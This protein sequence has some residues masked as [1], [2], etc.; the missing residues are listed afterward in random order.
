MSLSEALKKESTKVRKCLVCEWLQELPETDQNS[1]NTW[2]NSGR[3]LA[4]L[5]RAS[6][7][8]TPPIPVERNAFERHC[9]DHLQ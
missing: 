8:Q 1:F 2:V 5:L 6:K 9:R 4:P 7:K 3:P